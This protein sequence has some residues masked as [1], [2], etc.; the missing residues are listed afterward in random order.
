MITPNKTS[1]GWWRVGS[2]K[3]IYGRFARGFENKS[4]K[5]TMYFDIK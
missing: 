1:V 4:G 3:S 5:N 2:G